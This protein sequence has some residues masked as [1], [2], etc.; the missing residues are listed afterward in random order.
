[1]PDISRRDVLRGASYAGVASVGAVTGVGTHAFL[2]DEE[3]FEQTRASAGSF[4]LQLATRTTANG[5]TTFSPPE[6]GDPF[7][8]AFASGSTVDVEFPE[9]DPTGGPASGSVTLAVQVCENP[10]WVW[11]RTDGTASK[12]TDAIDVTLSYAETCGG[13]QVTRYEGPLTGLFDLLSGGVQLN[14]GCRPLGKA[15]VED[16]ALVV[17]TESGSGDSLAIDDI[18]GDLTFQGP[19]GPVTVTVTGGHWKEDGEL[20][21][22]DIESSAV[23]FCRVDVKGGGKQTGDQ[24]GIERYR[25]DCASRATELLAGDTPSGQPSGLSHFTVYTCGDRECIGCDPACLTLD[26]R[27][28][29]AKRFADESLAFAFDLFAEQCRHEEEGENPW[30]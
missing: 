15:E 13:E 23:E 22:V 21:G 4:D 14:G 10:G 8:S 27:L 1:M 7:P 5:E 18:P 9:I 28:K 3:L 26:W 30:Q 16:G 2:T 29:R 12:L 24:D 6:S 20:R 19:D 17:E 25:F 11:L